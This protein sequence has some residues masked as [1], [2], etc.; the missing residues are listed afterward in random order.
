[1]K[2]ST[3]DVVVIG[4]LLKKKVLREDKDVGV[5]RYVKLAELLSQVQNSVIL[6]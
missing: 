6:H 3:D 2:P 5:Y 4:E 1:M